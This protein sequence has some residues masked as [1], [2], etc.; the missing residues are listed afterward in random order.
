MK[1]FKLPIILFLISFILTIAVA[2][3]FLSSDQQSKNVM[4]KQGFDFHKLRAESPDFISP[5]VGEKLD[6]ENLKNTDGKSLLSVSGEK[7][8]LLVAIDP[9]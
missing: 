9:S 8:F 4:L 3:I 1:I 5:K 6:L 2:W 7:L